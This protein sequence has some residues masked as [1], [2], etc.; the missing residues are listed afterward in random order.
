M[1]LSAPAAASKIDSATTSTSAPV[2]GFD[3]L[4]VLVD[5]APSG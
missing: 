1:A 3:D 5:G 2:R 4:A